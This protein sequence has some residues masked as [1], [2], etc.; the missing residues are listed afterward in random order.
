MLGG[1]MLM[2]YTKESFIEAL[3]VSV[4]PDE[5]GMHFDETMAEYDELGAPYL[6]YFFLL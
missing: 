5:F 1:G 3:G 2:K 6:S 4:M